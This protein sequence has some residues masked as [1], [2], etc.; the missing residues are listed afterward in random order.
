SVYVAGLPDAADRPDKFIIVEVD[1]S[2]L[3][4]LKAVHAKLETDLVFEYVLNRTAQPNDA[5]LAG[6]PA[7]SL[8]INAT[9]LGKDRPGSPLT[10][11][12]VFPENGLVWELNY[13]GE[14]QFMHQALGQAEAR[15]L[16]VVDGWDYFLY[17]WSQVIA[18]VFHLDLT[19]EKF[20]ALDKA[21]AAIKS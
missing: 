5:L 9:G 3:D 16:T 21:A 8:V 19:S 20:A 15:R 17:G 4:K 10:D 1:P 13:R 2:R 18:E 14:R 7:G 12:A 11:A 6:L